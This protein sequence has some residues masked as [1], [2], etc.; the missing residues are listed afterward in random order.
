[1][2]IYYGFRFTRSGYHDRAL[3]SRDDDEVKSMRV[4][5]RCPALILDAESYSTGRMMPVDAEPSERGNIRLERV[6]NKLMAQVCG[7]HNLHF[8][9]TRGEK[10]YLS[11]FAS[12]PEAQSFR[13][14]AATK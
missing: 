2:T 6:G 12:C 7:K 13:K 8:Y 4:C 11:H 1:M 3:L 9:R 10:L 5:Q 14:K